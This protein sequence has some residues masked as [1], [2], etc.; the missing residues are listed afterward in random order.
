VELSTDPEYLRYLAELHTKLGDVL[1]DGGKQDQAVSAY[2]AAIGL[3]KKQAAEFA[4]VPDYRRILATSHNNLA[5]LLVKVGKPGQAETEI[6]AALDLRKQLVRDDPE[7]VTYRQHLAT[8]HV[9]LGSLLGAANKWPQAEIEFRAALAHQKVVVDKLSTEP[10]AVTDL[11]MILVDLGHAVALAGRRKDSLGWYDQGLALLTPLVEK[12]PGLAS[13]RQGLFHGHAGRALTF[14]E[15]KRYEDAVKDWARALELAPRD[16][17]ADCQTPLMYS[18]AR[19][20]QLD[21]ALKDADE[22]AR[23]NAKDPLYDG[24][25]VY[26]LAH[27][28][29]KEDRHAAHAV[30]LLRRAVAQGFRNVVHL[31]EDADFDSIRN[32]NDFRKLLAELGKDK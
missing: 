9:L 23:S 21:A 22:L 10:Q 15:L 26:A 2:R 13:A 14:D 20:G 11:G 19:A 25:C 5:D 32:R 4:A 8:A 28:K 24:A 1:R 6:R 27:A 7:D 17:R 30:E 18:R 29:T 3:Q 16:K 31:K 12:D